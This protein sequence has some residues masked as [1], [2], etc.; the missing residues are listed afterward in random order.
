MDWKKLKSNFMSSSQGIIA[1]AGLITKE[2]STAL[3]QTDWVK[4]LNKYTSEI[5]KSMDENFLKDGISKIMTPSNHRI[6]DGGHDFFTTIEKAQEIGLQNGWDSIT[7]FQEWAKSYFT[8]LSSNAGM[9]VFGNF[10]DE[11][12]TF[13]RSVNISEQVARDFVTING[14]E[15]IDAF[16]SGAVSGIALVLGW[17][18]SDKE[19]FSKSIGSI[20]CVSTITMNP[21]SLSIAVI[22]LA[23]GYNKLV[24]KEAVARGAIVSSFGLVISAIIPGPVLLGLFPAILA[25][26]YLHKKMGN[27]FKPI[28]Y[29]TQIYAL[30]T[31][32]NFKNKCKELF[33]EM[34]GKSDNFRTNSAA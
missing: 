10:S 15:A 30:L 22:A 18:N 26:V 31:S 19:S 17:K 6:M 5:S 27:D 11:I 20:L 4:D 25:S 23:F 12:Y 13:L 29:S 9:P 8:D 3:S 1:S 24:C 32:D 28:Q 7:T 2:L 16:L 21:V 14:Q 33:E 34:R